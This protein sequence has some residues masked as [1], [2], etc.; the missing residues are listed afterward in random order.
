MVKRE[1]S[2]DGIADVYVNLID[3]IGYE[4]TE[5]IFTA[6][7]GQQVSFPK[8]FYKSEY[9]AQQVTE[10]Y[11]GTNLRELAIQYDYTER[12]LRKMMRENEHNE[13]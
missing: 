9:V 8:R 2:K 4:S 5:K 3:L 10:A 11:D 1:I 7:K 6:F 12:H 13:K